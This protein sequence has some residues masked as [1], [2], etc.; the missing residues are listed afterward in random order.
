MHF[1][2]RGELLK[3][4]ISSKWVNIFLKKKSNFT[5]GQM[6]ALPVFLWW[7]K[8]KF[9]EN[10]KTYHGVCEKVKTVKVKRMPFLYP[11]R[12]VPV[13]YSFFP[14]SRAHTHVANNSSG[15]TLIYI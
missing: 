5:D 11:T 8:K 4:V 3:Y 15:G 10:K 12:R 13:S 6:L 2:M 1:I 7:K 14:G 9:H